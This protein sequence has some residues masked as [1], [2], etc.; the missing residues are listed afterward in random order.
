MGRSVNLITK[1]TGQV[2][3]LL[4]GTVRPILIFKGSGAPVDGTTGAG[5]ADTGSEYT[6]VLTGTKY[7]NLGSKTSPLWVPQGG[8]VVGAIEVYNGTGGSLAAGTLVYLSGWDATT[9]L[10]KI[11]KADADAGP[12]T[13]AQYVLRA[14]IADSASG[15]AGRAYQL[16]GQATNGTTVGDPVYLSATAG[17]WTATIPSGT[18]HLQIVGRISVVHASTGKVEFNVEPP[19]SGFLTQTV[20]AGGAAGNLTVTG[21]AVGDRL[22]SVARLDRDATAANV[23]LAT[24]TSEFTI[25]ATDTINNTSGT[26]TTGDALLVT[27][28]DRT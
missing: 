21:V 20:I 12:K 4:I 26:N 11:T 2:G 18:A 3:A 14:T 28:I 24:L 1:G 25:S 13:F 22:V 23:T 9:G 8:A 5:D 6:D 16:T 7:N 27:Y 10:P 19:I 17:G 15:L